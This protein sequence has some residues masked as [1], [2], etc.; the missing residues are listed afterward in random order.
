VPFWQGQVHYINGSALDDKDLKRA[1]LRTADACFVL[2]GKR[3]SPPRNPNDQARH[4]ELIDHYDSQNVLYALM[5][6]NF[7]HHVDS[8]VQVRGLEKRY[9]LSAAE[10]DV[11]MCIDRLRMCILGS[12]AIYPGLCA[13]MANLWQSSSEITY[14]KDDFDID[15]DDPELKPRKDWREEYLRCRSM[16]IYV[17]PVLPLFAGLTFTQAAFIVNRAFDGGITLL[18]VEE[19]LNAFDDYF[20]SQ[21]DINEPFVGLDFRILRS[22]VAPGNDY[23]FPHCPNLNKTRAERK[24]TARQSIVSLQV[25]RLEVHAYFL[26]VDADLADMFCKTS[27]FAQNIL[28]AF[29]EYV[30]LCSK[31]KPQI[32]KLE[33]QKEKQIEILQKHL[34]GTEDD[35]VE[36]KS[37]D[38]FKSPKQR[39]TRYSLAQ[40]TLDVE[41]RIL[42]S[43]EEFNNHY[44]I[45]A[46]PGS[47]T[48]IGD[49]LLPLRG[50][51]QLKNPKTIPRLCDHIVVLINKIELKDLPANFMRTVSSYQDVFVVFGDHNV[52]SDLKR[53]GIMTCKSIVILEDTQDMGSH[54]NEINTST[55]TK[56]LSTEQ[57]LTMTAEQNDFLK[58]PRSYVVETNS[59]PTMAIMNRS[60]LNR[61]ANEKIRSA[62][63]QEAQLNN[64]VMDVAAV[65]AQVRIKQREMRQ[66]DAANEKKMAELERH[67]MIQTDMAYTMTPF[68]ACGSCFSTSVFDNLLVLSYFARGVLRF[69][70]ALLGLESAQKPTQREELLRLNL[71]P[72]VRSGQIIQIPIP[73]KR[74]SGPQLTFTQIS[75]LMLIH[76][77]AVV[78][79][80]FRAGGLTSELPYIGL[81]RHGDKVE[82]SDSLF[83]V[84]PPHQIEKLLRGTALI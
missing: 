32:M 73:V 2:I 57:C 6:E 67:Q 10:A 72:D 61:M 8:F 76:Y 28:H 12:T 49:C 7:N 29:H 71:N 14:I 13:F 11:V 82:W 59:K 50:G 39:G 48:S 58:R 31:M 36:Q 70:E 21:D 52:V 64:D 55:I 18:G 68:F 9:S 1:G 77:E 4:Q 75:D 83:V 45:M 80:V 43:A 15:E 41:S 51:E 22:L 54:G 17:R 3:S 27:A 60:V 16:E 30:F 44:I 56:F 19:R 35:D 47:L 20:E 79:G 46:P 53:A 63:L 81:P 38:S 78:V 62:V 5:V 25:E 24:N 69:T 42:R 26:C 33:P 74:A 84:A 65:A 37:V 40:E 66:K 23:I 34:D